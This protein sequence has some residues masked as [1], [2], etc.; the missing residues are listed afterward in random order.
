MTNSM[1]TCFPHVT[2]LALGCLADVVGGTLR[3]AAMPPRDGDMTAVERIVT[4]VRHVQRGDVFW[5]IPGKPCP[6]GFEPASDCAYE[7]LMRGAAGVVAN[8]R[9]EPFAGRWSIE[10]ADPVVALW[11]LARWKRDRFCGHLIALCGDSDSLTA[12]LV[13]C[14]MRCRMAGTFASLRGV[15]KEQPRVAL[16]LALMEIDAADEYAVVEMNAESPE[17]AEAATRLCRPKVV[18]VSSD[19]DEGA[20]KQTLSQLSSD[21]F[22]VLCGDEP[23]TRRLTASTMATVRTFGRNGNCDYAA[24]NIEYRDGL[25]HCEIEGT[26]LCVRAWGRHQLRAVLAAYTLGRVM[27]FTPHEIAAALA[28]FVPPPEHCEVTE[29]EGLTILHEATRGE[30]QSLVALEL[31]RETAA[32]GRRLVLC[33][34]EDSRGDC[35]SDSR[36]RFG[37]EVV[38]RAGA[39]RLIAYGRDARDVVTAARDAGMPL[40]HAI[41]CRELDDAA[42]YVAEESRPGDVLLINAAPRDAIKKIVIVREPRNLGL[43]RAA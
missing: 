22:V 26:P 20:A 17:Q 10:V 39:D 40:A 28:A 1:P 30:K 4:D 2:D 19:A 33:G 24:T 29:V 18:V 11:E 3:L 41:A 5:A 35:D 15:A 12:L 42:R 34:D 25:L 31:L 8:H 14:V 38:C 37:S 32:R 13:D 21:C 36:K 7:A 43:R 27:E 6:S 16:P 23:S 9:V